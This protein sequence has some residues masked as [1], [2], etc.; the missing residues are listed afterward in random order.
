[1]CSSGS[2]SAQRERS[3]SQ[4]LPTRGRRDVAMFAAS[5]TGLVVRSG[6]EVL[7]VDAWGRAASGCG[8]PSGHRSRRRPEAP[9]S[10]TE[11]RLPRSR[12]PMAA[13]AYRNGDLVVEVRENAE[14]RFVPF[15]P[16]VRFL[17]AD[18]SSSS[19]RALPTSRPPPSAATAGAAA[20]STPAKSRSTPHPEE[21]FYGLGQHQHGL[22]D[23]KGA[24]DRPRPAQHRGL[25]AVRALQPRLRVPVEHAGRRP[26]RAG[27]QPHEVGRRRSPADRL[28]GDD[29]RHAGRH[30]QP[31]TRARRGLP[32]ML[33]DWASGFWQSKLRYRNQ[34]ELLE[35][36]REYKRRGLP[37]SVIVC[38][39]FHWTRQGEWKFDP[40]EWPDPQAMVDELRE[41]GVELM[42]SI[43]PTVNPNSENYA[44]MER[45]RASWCATW[46]AACRSTWRSGTRAPTATP[47]CAST[48]RPT[49]KRG[50]TSGRRSPTVTA[51]TASG[52]SGSTRASRRSSPSNPENAR[53]FLGQGIGGAGRLSAR[54]RAGLLRGAASRAVRT[55]CCCFAGPPGRAASATGRPSGRATSSRP[56]R[57]S[58]RR[59]RPA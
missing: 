7:Q 28:L 20:T 49:R 21:R 58:P 57:L 40:A 3:D 43:W 37:L 45:A 44:E 39:Y 30:R 34:E 10:R 23:Q 4:A 41:L 55:T 56:S 52:R 1:M 38:D 32:P 54:A 2:L 6:G 59:S 42:V 31:T 12:S 36:A 47:S 25:G 35:V 48:T 15:P 19:A 46:Q 50:A 51:A 16:L 11:R 9:W 13:R 53:Y 26:R 29:R 24:V 22:L 33:P 18:G 27:R 14:D 17:R 5:E 8:R